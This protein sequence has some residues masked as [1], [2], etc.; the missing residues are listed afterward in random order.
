MAKNLLAS[1]PAP[2]YGPTP[3]G[4][5]SSASVENHDIPAKCQRILVTLSV[6]F[7]SVSTEINCT[8]ESDLVLKSPRSRL[9]S[10]YGLFPLAAY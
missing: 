4:P 2:A 8:A 7:N 5:S 1:D 3:T 10:R 9:R 6:V